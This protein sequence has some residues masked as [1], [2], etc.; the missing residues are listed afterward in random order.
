MSL[1]TETVEALAV[2][3]PPGESLRTT[4]PK[5]AAPE[6][7]FSITRTERGLLF[8]CFRA[9]CGWHGR[10]TEDPTSWHPERIKRQVKPAAPEVRFLPF[11]AEIESWFPLTAAERTKYDIH[12]CDND[13]VLYRFY[14]DGQEGSVFRWYDGRVPKCKRYGPAPYAYYYGRAAPPNV[15]ILVEDCLSAAV[16]HATLGCAAL[17]L[18][19]TTLTP[20]TLA[21]L[22]DYILMLDPDAAALTYRYCQMYNGLVHRLVPAIPPADPK[23]MKREDLREFVSEILASEAWNKN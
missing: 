15:C 5:C 1:L 23:D 7:A 4:C 20:A 9:S 11:P 10:L 12:Y 8:K 22:S 19:G 14:G 17:A 3:L 18:L 6:K 21:G 2:A 13:A 16:I